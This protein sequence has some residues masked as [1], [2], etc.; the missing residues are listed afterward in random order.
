LAHRLISQQYITSIALGVQ[1]DT[2][3]IYKYAP[4]TGLAI[5]ELLDQ[6]LVALR[7]PLGML[8]RW[9]ARLR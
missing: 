4:W 1:R 6:R 9:I 2:I 3:G 7:A 5:V 8:S